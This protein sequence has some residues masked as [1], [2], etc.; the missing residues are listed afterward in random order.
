MQD[1]IMRR[2]ARR[3]P[4]SPQHGEAAV[5][6]SVRD[7]YERTAPYYDILDWPC[8]VARYRRIRPRLFEGLSGRLLDVGVGTGRNIPCYPPG[9]EVTGIDLSPAM[10]VRARRRA[11]R[12]RRVVRL[13]CMDVG[14]IAF[15]DATFDAAVASFVFC[16]L[17]G[18]AGPLALR[19]I[20]RVVRAGG[21]IRTLDFIRP[22][23]WAR[24]ALARLWEPW[25][26][27]A[28]AAGFGGV[29]APDIASAGLEIIGCEMVVPDLVRMLTLRLPE[30]PHGRVDRATK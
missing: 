3:G 16:V 30:G 11:E 26:R 22:A 9:S 28:F 29:L 4:L 19:E 14:Q 23:G 25:M 10:L 8:E 13:A 27:F 2:G 7:T 20:A 24:G 15:A 5:A 1:G 21:T 12:S 17:P 18:G 6:R